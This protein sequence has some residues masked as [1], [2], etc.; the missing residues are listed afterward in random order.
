MEQPTISN[1]T[2]EKRNK[3]WSEGDAIELWKYFGGIGG[4]DKNTMVLVCNWLL[5]FSVVII[6]FAFGKDIDK[7]IL[8]GRFVVWMPSSAFSSLLPQGSSV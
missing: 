4:G 7:S 6:G 5:G 3:P 8:G 2:D 1:P